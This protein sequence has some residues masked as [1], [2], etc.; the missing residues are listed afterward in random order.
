RARA[1]GELHHRAP[2]G[3]GQ[4]PRRARSRGLE[5]QPVLLERGRGRGGG[6]AARQVAH[7]TYGGDWVL[8]RVPWQ[9]RRRAAGPGIELQTR[10]GS[11]DAGGVPLALRLMRPVRVRENLPVMRM[12]WCRLPA[13]DD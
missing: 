1:R 12:A 6:A 2:G 13:Q 7:G 8:G 9:D 4:A 10:T 5:P 3:V 11:A